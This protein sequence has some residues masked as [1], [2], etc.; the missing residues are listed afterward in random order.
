[1][2]L[3]ADDMLQRASLVAQTNSCN[4]RDPGPIPG[5]E[6]SRGEGN[7][8][9]L[10]NSCLENP[11]AEEPGGLQSKGHKELDITEQLTHVPL[12]IGNSKNYTKNVRQTKL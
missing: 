4:D 10:Q 3:F 1:M 8:S 5:L 2:S 9:P 12:Y 6:R 11:M 7:V